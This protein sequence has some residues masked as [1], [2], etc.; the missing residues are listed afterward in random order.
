MKPS[1]ETNDLQLFHGDCLEG[2]QRLPDESVDLVIT[3]PPYNKN[4]T[5][6]WYSAQWKDAFWKNGLNEGYGEYKDALPHE[7]YV[8]W[9]KEVLSECWR[10]IKP[11]GAIFYN[12]KPK[13]CNKLLQTPLELNPGLP[14][15]QI[16]I[17]HTN[18]RV[19]F[20]QH[21]FVPAHEW[22]LIFA[23]PDFKLKSR[24]ASKLSDV[25]TFMAEKDPR[26]PAP[27]PIELPRRILAS[28]EGKVILDPFMGSGT[29]GVAC[30]ETGRKFLGIEKEESY[31]R[32]AVNRL[33][34]II[35][36]RRAD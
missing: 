34:E 27:F 8:A 21:H 26:H 25:W 22:I 20:S 10:V 12:H 32:I 15:R 6:N 14:L 13:P 4:T 18:S 35:D 36:V 2:M 28:V 29:T 11:T 24:S 17:W 16:L 19:N 23:G 9:Q 1:F 30:M 5:A 3:S 33:R 7:E 31:F